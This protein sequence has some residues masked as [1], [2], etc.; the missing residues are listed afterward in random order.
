M[1]TYKRVFFHHLC[2]GL[3]R[4]ALRSAEAVLIPWLF[5]SP[6]GRACL[7]TGSLISEIVIVA[8]ATTINEQLTLHRQQV[9][10]VTPYISAARSCLHLH[11]T[12]LGDFFDFP[13]CF[14][15]VL[16]CLKIVGISIT[17]SIEEL[18]TRLGVPVIIILG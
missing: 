10:S 6:L 18:I 17:T 5:I 2:S 9:V 12:R 11:P 8:I 16:H 4:I 14:L 3:L 7:Q 1:Q 13:T 15:T